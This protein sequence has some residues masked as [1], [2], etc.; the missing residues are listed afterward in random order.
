MALHA[1]SSDFL[2]PYPPRPSPDRDGDPRQHHLSDPLPSCSASITP[3]TISLSLVAPSPGPRLLP[4]QARR[5]LNT[6]VHH[7]D[8]RPFTEPSNRHCV[9]RL[10]RSESASWSPSSIAATIAY[11]AGSV[12]LPYRQ[13]SEIIFSRQGVTLW[14][15]EGCG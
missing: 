11:F 12:W 1:N 7:S 6:H 9:F 5:S 8:R 10:H 13:G 15:W 3:P 2:D 4:G 14:P